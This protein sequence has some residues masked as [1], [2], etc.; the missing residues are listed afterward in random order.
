MHAKWFA[1]PWADLKWHPETMK[2]ILDMPDELP[3]DALRVD[4]DRWLEEIDKWQ[5]EKDLQSLDNDYP[6]QGYLP[7]RGIVQQAM[8]MGR[9]KVDTKFEIDIDATGE[10]RFKIVDASGGK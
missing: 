9:R 2:F 8:T 6:L 3:K 1:M 5:E 4:K 7:Y 10:Y